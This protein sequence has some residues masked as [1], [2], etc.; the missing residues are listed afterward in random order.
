MNEEA[1]EWMDGGILLIFVLIKYI[2]ISLDLRGGVEGIIVCIK[3]LLLLLLFPFL[4]SLRL[5]NL[6]FPD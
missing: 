3:L 2:I 6:E 4:N 1:T 5:G